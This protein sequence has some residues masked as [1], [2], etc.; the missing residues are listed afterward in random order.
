MI[1]PTL[2]I[3]NRYKRFFPFVSLFLVILIHLYL[4]GVFTFP[5]ILNPHKIF[6]GGLGGDKYQFIWGFWWYKHALTE[7]FTNPLF[8]HLQY[9]PDGVSLAYHDMS[10]FW[11]LLS[12]PLQ[13][14]MHPTLIFNL[15]LLVSIFLNGMCFYKLALEISQNKMGSLFGSILFAYC[16]YFIGRF[17]VGH[18]VYFY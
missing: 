6:V 4:T 5:L 13:A 3:L 1:E 8:T 15:F 14:F 17:R 12:V 16:P 18:I 2:A 7:I 11:T 9:Y 10:Y